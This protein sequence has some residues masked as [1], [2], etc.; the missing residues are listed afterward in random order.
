MIDP[1]WYGLIELLLV[2]GIALGLGVWQWISVN[3]EIARGRARRDDG[4]PP[5]DQA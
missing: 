4:P 3:R 1:R 2:G 5:P